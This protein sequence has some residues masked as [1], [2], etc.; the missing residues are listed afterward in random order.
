LV[1]HGLWPTFSTNG[2]YQGWP[3]FCRTNQIDWS[4]CHID[5]N[6]CPWTNATKSGF[7]QG[8]YEYCLAIEG[9]QPCLVDP[10][11]VLQ[12]EYE[13]LKVFAPGYL[14]EHNLFINHEWTKHGQ[15]TTSQQ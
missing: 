15:Y 11:I 14:G 12:S 7:T 10:T 8:D 9:K 2:D 1:L 6:L 13:R 4:T 3:Q 5:G